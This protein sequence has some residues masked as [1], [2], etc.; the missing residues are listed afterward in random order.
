VPFGGLLIAV[1]DRFHTLHNGVVD[2][3]SVAST[4]YVPSF[5]PFFNHPV[6]RVYSSPASNLP[7]SNE[8]IV[9][10]PLYRLNWTLDWLYANKNVDS[11][12]VSL[13]GHSGGAKGSLLWS[14]ASPERFSLVGLY[15]PALG[16][17]PD[18]DARYIG[19]RAQNLP[20]LLTNR[21]GQLVRALDIHQFTASYSP[22]RDLPF[23][24]IFMGKREENWVVDD[25]LDGRGD[26]EFTF[27]QSDALGL[28][29]ALFW[30]LRSHGVDKWTYNTLTNDL[31][32]PNNC[33]PNVSTNVSGSWG[34][35]DLWVP[36]L[37]L[38]YRRDDAT[39]HLRHRADQSY[40]AFFNCS[41]RGG[42]GE[43]GVVVYTNN[44]VFYDGY[45][46]YDGLVTTTECRPPSTGDTRGTWGGY[47]EWETNIVD[48]ATNWECVVYLVG[49]S[50]AFNPVEICPDAARVADIAIRRPQQ[51]KPAAGTLLNW[52]LRNAA[53]NALQ[54]SGTTIVGADDLVSVANLTI[55]RDPVRA[56]L[57]ITGPGPVA[58]CAPAPTLYGSLLRNWWGKLLLC[59]QVESHAGG[60]FS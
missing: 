59:N 35:G 5:D 57:I 52:E 50:S 19:T 49:A 48:T 2:P 32:H 21:Q 23:T 46:P 13:V 51:F 44:T 4:G 39:N 14:H 53:N 16:D 56:R 11:N 37:S 40:P 28:G 10:Y 33:S 1:E 41:L 60:G 8:V 43:V 17:F 20:M 30:D 9:P 54:Q 18:T 27:R 6:D 24:R 12:R 31:A 42:H 15:N 58:P 7:G 26:V 38:Q 3:E 34:F 47:F 25:N 29:A 55:P 36:T 45:T 22:R